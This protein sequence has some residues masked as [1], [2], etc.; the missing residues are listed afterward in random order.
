[1]TVLRNSHLT[2]PRGGSVLWQKTEAGGTVLRTSF[3]GLPPVPPPSGGGLV[4]V[5]L[6]ASWVEKSVKVWNGS[7]WVVKPVKFWNGAAWVT[8]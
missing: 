2:K 8:S 4:K 6:G 1:M 7:A 5:W 3:F